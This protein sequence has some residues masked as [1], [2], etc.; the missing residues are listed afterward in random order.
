VVNATSL[1]LCP[2]ER[3]LVRIAQKAE[4]APGPVWTGA[5]YLGLIGIRSPDR[6]ARN[7][8][9]CRLTGGSCPILLVNTAV[10]QCCGS[11]SAWGAGF[12][13]VCFGCTYLHI[14]KFL[15]SLY[16]RVCVSNNVRI[17]LTQRVIPRRKNVFISP[18]VYRSTDFVF[19]VHC[20]CK[21]S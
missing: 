8:S 9:L 4:W 15:V 20:F 12:A 13:A 16:V 3:D 11:F 2:R 6:P 1:L 17:S 7:E 14:Y 18:S 21:S 5:E 10:C 19:L